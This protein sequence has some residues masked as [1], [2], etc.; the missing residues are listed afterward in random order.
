MKN[1]MV[2]IPTNP[3]DCSAMSELSGEDDKPLANQ[4]GV[5]AK[6]VEMY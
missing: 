1:T 6:W 2:N 3:A 4:C 5:L